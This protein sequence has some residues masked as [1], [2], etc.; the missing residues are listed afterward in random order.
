MKRH[1]GWRLRTAICESFHDHHFC[2]WTQPLVE[3]EIVAVA[4]FGVMPDGTSHVP[5]VVL[6]SVYGFVLFVAQKNV[7]TFSVLG[8][9]K[10]PMFAFDLVGQN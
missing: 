3:E 2:N 10:C 5:R 6:E 9:L 1:R 4:L 7:V 8:A